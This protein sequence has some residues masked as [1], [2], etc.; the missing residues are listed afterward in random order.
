VESFELRELAGELRLDESGEPVCEAR[1][2]GQ[3]RPVRFPADSYE[4]QIELACD[5]DF[6]RLERLE[7]RRDGAAPRLWLALWPT[8]MADNTVLNAQV[9]PIPLLIPRDIWLEFLRRSGFAEYELL[10]IRYPAGSSEHLARAVGYLRDARSRI[11]AGDYASAAAACRKVIEAALEDSRSDGTGKDWNQILSRL[12][13]DKR[14]TEYSGI[15]GRLKQLSG[16]AH[17]DYGSDVSFT[18]S[19]ALFLVRCTHAFLVLVAHLNERQADSR[20]H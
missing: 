1:S 14:G 7:Q 4:A 3:R 2:L 19:D 6:P 16:F 20:S 12:T 17:H 18:R 15:A 11:D 9:L 8:V 10:E 13:D 5:F